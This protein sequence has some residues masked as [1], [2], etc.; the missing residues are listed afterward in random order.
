MLRADAFL[1]NL[2]N[3]GHDEL[4]LYDN[5]IVLAV[6]VN[7]IH[8]VQPVSAAGRYADH[9]AEI[10][11]RF[12]KRSIL[13][14]GIADQNIIISIQHEEGNQFLCR[15]RLTGAGNT[16]EK[17]RLVQ[18]VCLVAHDKVMGN[19]VFS[20]EDT[21]LVHNLLH[22]E[23]HEHRKALCGQRSERIDLA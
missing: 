20:E 1:V 6:A 2:L 19:C 4:R 5:R 23:R 8:G 15:E 3:E 12:N 18:K 9:R 21:A 14:F 13:T 7:H 10:A 17:C 11:H 22:L 16:K